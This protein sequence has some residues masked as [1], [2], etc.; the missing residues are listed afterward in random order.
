MRS[1]TAMDRFEVYLSDEG[2]AE[3]DGEPVRT[4]PGRSV[5]EAVLDRLQRY[6]QE[7]GE[8]VEA[9][10]NQG[11][12]LDDFALQVSPDGSS[13]LLLPADPPGTT[14][15]AEGERA[16][17][18]DE[19]DEGA[20][21]ERGEEATPVSATSATSTTSA[22]SAASALAAV[23][24]RA[25]A[26][27]RETPAAPAAPIAPAAPDS[28]GLPLAFTKRIARVNSLAADGRL[29]DAYAAATALRKSL[30][31]EVGAD[32]PHALE[33]RSLEAYVAHLAG[34]HREAVVLALG[35]ARIRCG[36]GDLRAPGDVAR[37]AAFWQ[38]LDDDTAA[39]THGLEL[40]HMWDALHR[41]GLLAP[42]HRLIAE[43]VRGYVDSLTPLGPLGPLGLL[44]SRQSPEPPEPAESVKPVKP[45]KP[46][47]SADSAD[48]AEPVEYA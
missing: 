35:V 26:A 15:E 48:S 17:E 2:P 1:T 10:V 34:E 14:E 3:I 44:G 40:L 6:A 47:E 19:G 32:D 27:A 42:G 7:R 25:R 16:A 5:H 23:V 20:E 43:R 21:G 29:E 24:G 37:A 13:R 38:R 18:G 8:P 22:A 11:S 31:R 46:V 9:I 4:A 33:A 41:R 28:G 12:G 45:V 39:V 36:A 30:T